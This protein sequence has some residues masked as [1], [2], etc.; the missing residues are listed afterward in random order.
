VTSF[1]TTDQVIVHLKKVLQTGDV[2]LIKGSHGM[3]MDRIVAAMEVD[4]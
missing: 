1:D 2:V 4:K 3:R